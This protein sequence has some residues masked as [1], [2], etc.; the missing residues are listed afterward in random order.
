MLQAERAGGRPEIRQ[1]SFA[2]RI[3]RIAQSPYACDPGSSLLEQLDPLSNEP[4][5]EEAGHTRNVAPWSPEIRDETSPNRV[6]A[7]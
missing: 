6:T 4:S 2:D 5:A 3:A 7:H 1:E